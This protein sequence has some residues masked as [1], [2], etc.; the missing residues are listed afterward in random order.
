MPNKMINV[1][2]MSSALNGILPSTRITR[3]WV[4]NPPGACVT[5]QLEK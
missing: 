5:Y 2:P 4:E 3:S 1:V